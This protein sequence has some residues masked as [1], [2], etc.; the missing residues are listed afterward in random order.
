MCTHEHVCTHYAGRS[1]KLL[2]EAIALK[3]C[4]DICIHVCVYIYIYI[5]IH[6]CKCTYTRRHTYMYTYTYACVKAMLVHV[7]SQR[8]VLLTLLVD[9][10]LAN[11]QPGP[12]GT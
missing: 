10:R 6:T 3:V 12:T 1:I 11:F 9:S 8:I 7:S 4:I 2:K 5:Y